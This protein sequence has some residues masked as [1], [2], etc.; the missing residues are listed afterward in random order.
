MLLSS[1][2]RVGKGEG[3][4]DLEYGM[5]RHMKCVTEKTLI[6]TTVHDCQV[7]CYATLRRVCCYA[8]L[9]HVCV[10]MLHCDTCVDM[11]RCG[12]CVL[13]CYAA[14]DVVAEIFRAHSLFCNSFIRM[15]PKSWVCFII[16]IHLINSFANYDSFM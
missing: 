12:A 9:R 8:T 3:F 14:R 1:G 4:V 13:L 10:A 11:L 16:C 7:C 6:V 15:Q 2:H 5:M